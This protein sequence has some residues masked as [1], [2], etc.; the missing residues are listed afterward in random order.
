MVR[1]GIA[2]SLEME[3]EF[4]VVAEGETGEQAIEM[5][6]RVRPDAV[7]MDVRLPGTGGIEVT[8]RICAEFPEAR[9]LMYST[10]DH[11][12]EIYRSLQ[13]GAAVYVLKSAPRER[14]WCGRC[15]QSWRARATCRAGSRAA[16][17]YGWPGRP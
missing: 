2:A 7:L 6:R 9:V 1:S 17:P 16:S 13:A 14:R 4:A 5:Y 10:F 3:S 8:S 11:P 15:G 12:D